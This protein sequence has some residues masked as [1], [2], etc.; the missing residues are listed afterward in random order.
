M[1]SPGFCVTLQE[2]LQHRGNRG[3]VGEVAGAAQVAD[4]ERVGFLGSLGMGRPYLPDLI[5]QVIR[6]VQHAAVEIAEVLTNPRG[7]ADDYVRF[8]DSTQ[9]GQA[10]GQVAARSGMIKRQLGQKVI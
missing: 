10:P 7:A 6:Q 4:D 5:I 3:Q 9:D 2:P 1:G 8:Q